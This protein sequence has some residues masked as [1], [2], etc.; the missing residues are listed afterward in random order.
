VT[1]GYHFKLEALRRYRQ[2]Q[3]D[4][5][6]RELADALHHKEEAISTLAR[7][8]THLA[9]TEKEMYRQQTDSTNAAKLVIFPRF[10][11]R[12]TENISKQHYQ[13][14]KID[15]QCETLRE[16]LLEAVKKRKTLEKLEEKEFQ[17]YLAELSSEE[18][19][20]INEI[21]INQFNLKIG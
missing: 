13:I 6:Q 12:I 20:F 14:E 5:L 3:E 19:K 9:Q 18:Q 8:E 1:V 2:F 21:A 7:Y 15:K 10:L 17:S 4:E 16:A 11:Q